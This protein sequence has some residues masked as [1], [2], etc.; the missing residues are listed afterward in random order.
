[1]S[2]DFVDR[3]I[4][5]MKLAD[6]VAKSAPWSVE[7]FGEKS[8]NVRYV[9]LRIKD[10]LRE[11]FSEGNNLLLK[12]VIDR[13]SGWVEFYLANKPPFLKIL[14]RQFTDGDKWEILIGDFKRKMKKDK[15]DFMNHK[16]GVGNLYSKIKGLL[17]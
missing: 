17:K 2:K 12:F 3:M 14:S 4:R 13:G 9:G 10:D 8:K 6:L 7:G 5:N 1:M 11:V 16:E 15:N